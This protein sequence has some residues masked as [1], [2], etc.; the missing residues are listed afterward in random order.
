[1][2]YFRKKEICQ[3]ANFKK[4]SKKKKRKPTQPLKLFIVIPKAS[5]VCTKSLSCPIENKKD[6]CTYLALVSALLNVLKTRNFQVLINTPTRPKPFLPLPLH[7]AYSTLNLSGIKS[8][9]RPFIFHNK[10]SELPSF[11]FL[12]LLK[13]SQSL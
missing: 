4:K 3:Y 6:E 11:L 9:S 7:Q 12:C 13:T 10:K 5:P 8:F 1:M 2:C